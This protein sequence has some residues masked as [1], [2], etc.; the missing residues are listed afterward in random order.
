MR[1]LLLTASLF[2]S[3]LAFSQEDDV[4]TVKEYFKRQKEKKD[5]PLLRRYEPGLTIPPIARSPLGNL[6][7]LT[8]NGNRVYSL[9]TDNMPC[10]VPD[11]DQ[12]NM[13]C[14][15]P[16]MRQYNMPVIPKTAVLNN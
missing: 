11:M 6:S 4:P 9:R 16:E 15:K 2:S 14:I 12:F 3:V 5:L 7:H 1:K 10:L 8:T 13:P